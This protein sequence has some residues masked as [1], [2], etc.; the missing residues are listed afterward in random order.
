[1]LGEESM[2][3]A[4]QARNLANELVEFLKSEIRDTQHQDEWT[5][6]NLRLLREFTRAIEAESYP[7]AKDASPGQKAKQFLWDFIAYKPKKGVLLAVETEHEDKEHSILYD[8]EKLLYVRSPVKLMMCRVAGEEDALRI[9]GKAQEF[10]EQT[11]TLYS[12]GEV[13]VLYCVWWSGHEHDNRDFAYL[14]QIKGECDY[15][16]ITTERFE[17]I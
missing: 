4:E 11:C 3:S 17:P 2:Y 12:P 10:M 7:S 14:L 9:R 13:F 8:F 15:C 6:R 16:R 5:Q 1:M